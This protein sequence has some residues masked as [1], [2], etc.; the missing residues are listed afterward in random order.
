MTRPSLRVLASLW[1]VLAM[2]SGAGATW[3]WTT[4]ETA[5][6]DHLAR[7]YVTGL[8]LH[9]SL[10]N[11]GPAPSGIVL[12][13]IGSPPIPAP[14]WRE[15]LLTLTGGGRPDLTQ[16]QRLS[17]RIHSPDIQYPVAQV[18]SLGGPGQGAGLASITRMLAQ[19]CS[20]PQLFVQVGAGAWIRAEGDPVWGCAAAPPDRRLLAGGIALAALALLLG[21]VAEVSG[22]FSGFAAALRDHRT[23]NTPLPLGG[24]EE[25]RQTAE[26]VNTY[27]E[28]DR[29]ALE[30]R[31]MILSGVSHDLGTPATR[32]R[33]RSALIEDR[34]LRARLERDIDEMTGMIDSVLT[35]TRAEMGGEPFRRLSLTLLVEAVVADYQDV[36]LPV[37][38]LPTA[39][40]RASAG[41]LFARGTPREAGIQSRILMR[42]Q[43][44]S[45]RRALSNLIDNALK[46]GG[47]AEISVS[48]TP[49]EAVIEVT[50]HGSALSEAELLSLTGAF[51]RGRNSQGIPGAGLGLAIVSTIAAQHGGGLDFY[52]KNQC[53]VARL[54]VARSWA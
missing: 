7:A 11:G 46:Y 20:H 17:I 39:A 4:S 8:A 36:G 22:A 40:P 37:T 5:W 49:D 42:G 21:W 53:V 15:T 12:V 52:L 24:V 35:Y 2:L 50:N 34:E 33:L 10:L 43:P 19:Y 29:A 9:D 14:G 48:A 31:A 26:A 3:L 54:K 30:N 16:G 32:L 25:L 41:T 47:Q 51:R 23:R 45:L 28:A 38:L 1:V 13:P 18:R 27:V 44:T 6:R